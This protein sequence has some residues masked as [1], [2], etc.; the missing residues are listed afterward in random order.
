M[1]R[2]SGARR[3]GATAG[4]SA[5]SLAL[6]TGCGSDSGD[7]AGKPAAKA[8]A[9]TAAAKAY[10]EAELDKLIISAADLDGYDVQAA[11]SGDRYVDSKD[12]MTVADAACEPIAYVLSGF[13]PGDER[14]YVNR[15]ASE[16]AATPTATGT[17]DEDLDA[18]M[19]GLEDMLGSTV[20][21]V[22]LSSYD[23]SGAEETMKAVSDAVSGCAGGFTL[24]AKGEDTEKFTKVA[25][26]KS[27]GTG[28]ESVA[29]AATGEV[30]GGDTTTVHAEVVRHG[31]TIAT[32]YSLNLAAL[33]GEK[34]TYTIPAEVIKAQSAK[35]T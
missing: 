20:T 3:I 34:S 2:S 27:S 24:S 4:V 35:L 26:E 13:A 5:L 28:D 16:K 30:D 33:A 29:F 11:D 9:S 18:A 12:K 25:A 23:G 19:D 6:I 14:A 21:I 32:Y 7:D 22:S 15:M 1:K 8:S 31:S 10:S 17:S